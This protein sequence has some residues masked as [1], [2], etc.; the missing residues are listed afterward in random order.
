[1]DRGDA[2]LS[3]SSSLSPRSLA[4]SDA[5]IA[6]LAKTPPQRSSCCTSTCLPLCSKRAKKT[7]GEEEYRKAQLE[8]LDLVL[9]AEKRRTA[10]A[11]TI[12]EEE[13]GGAEATLQRQARFGINVSFSINLVLL[14]L[15]LVAVVVSNALVLWAS[16]V[17]SILDLLSNLIIFATARAQRKIDP[18]GYPIGRA[19]LEAVGI[20]AFAS[21]TGMG[22]LQLIREST[23]AIV[24]GAGGDLPQIEVGRR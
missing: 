7:Q 8:R 22:S 13:E 6:V 1:M 2:H 11:H 18:N 9:S 4:A 23:E 21:V 16:L 19:S 20:V 14:A 10:P 24:G 17:D 3:S 5:A 12:L 15:K